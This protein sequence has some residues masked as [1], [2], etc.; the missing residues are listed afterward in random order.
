MTR[1][2][3][4]KINKKQTGGTVMT[5][6]S[7]EYFE[8]V[9]S[10]LLSSGQVPHNNSNYK[11]NCAPL[12]M[13]EL[14]FYH[15]YSKKHD[16]LERCFLQGLD[17]EDVILFL[18]ASYTPTNH[19][20]FPFY[21]QSDKGFSELESN[22][23]EYLKPGEAIL[24]GRSGHMFILFNEGSKEVG[25]FTVREPQTNQ[26]FSLREYVAG[27]IRNGNEY[28][29]LLYPLASNGTISKGHRVSV[30]DPP[31]LTERGVQIVAEKEG[32]SSYKF[33]H[34]P[35]STFDLLSQESQASRRAEQASRSAELSS[36]SAEQA[37]EA[38]K[39]KTNEWNSSRQGKILKLKRRS[40]GRPGIND[41]DQED[42]ERGAE[43]IRGGTRKKKQEK[44]KT[45]FCRL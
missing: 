30:H 15:S 10:Q 23:K 18:N 14:G 24:A 8:H 21:I 27:L 12:A 17:F 32:L 5:G 31:R 2:R 1:S 34:K 29:Y 36:R 35:G 22:L 42:Q 43:S 25:I 45:K 38:K 19:S 6:V 13:K 44:A 39:R 7:R 41:E 20:F 3:K 40:K 28:I 33:L 4:Q 26:F 16:F 11:N 37:S 9:Y